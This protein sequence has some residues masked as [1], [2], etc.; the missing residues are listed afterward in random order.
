M[1]KLKKEKTKIT[2]EN[3]N[4]LKEKT[5][6]KFILFLINELIKDIKSDKRNNFYEMLN[7][8]RIKN[9]IKK[10]EKRN[11]IKKHKKISKD[12]NVYVFEIKLGGR[13]PRIVEIRGNRLL[14]DLSD[15]I[16]RLFDHEPMHLYE[17]RL[18]GYNFGPE[19]DEWQEIFDY[20]D[21][22]R[23]DSA[24]NSVDF[25]IGDVGEFI[26]DFGEEIR[27]KIK[28][29]DIKKIKKWI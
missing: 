10:E 18:K 9:L 27:H 7:F 16:Q 13:K 29:V 2:E 1:N 17:F 26:Y 21:N 20:L 25:K 24:L 3:L 11:K 19:C 8:E 4:K 5:K 15:D 6:D 12:N 22:I 23:I 14:S 28:L